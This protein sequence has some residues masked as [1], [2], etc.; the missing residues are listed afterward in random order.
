MVSVNEAIENGRKGM[1]IIRERYTPSEFGRMGGKIGGKARAKKLTKE[2]RSAISR[3]GGIAAAAKRS[4]KPCSCGAKH[5]ARGMCR[6]CYYRAY[7]AG[8]A[9]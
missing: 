2:Q 3:L 5:Y 9:D 6:L 1:A 7:R 8:R 4:T